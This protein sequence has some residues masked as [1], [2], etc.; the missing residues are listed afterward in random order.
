MLNEDGFI[1]NNKMKTEKNVI[2][3]SPLNFVEYLE[4]LVEIKNVKYALFEHYDKTNITSGYITIDIDGINSTFSLLKRV[5]YNVDETFNYKKY[6]DILLPKRLMEIVFESG[7]ISEN[8][9]DPFYDFER[10]RQKEEFSKKD[11]LILKE[12]LKLIMNDTEIALAKNFGEFIKGAQKTGGKSLS[13]KT[14]KDNLLSSRNVKDF[15]DSLIAFCKKAGIEYTTGVP[16][17][18]IT[19]FVKKEKEKILYKFLMY[20]K[21]NM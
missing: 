11:I 17:D 9:I 3:V 14:E 20:T 21:F 19:Y 10:F 12:Y 1:L 4:L 8:I 13:L 6:S 2:N 5:V 18:V 7:E 16:Y 15:G